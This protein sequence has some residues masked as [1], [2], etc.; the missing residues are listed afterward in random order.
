[1]LIPKTHQTDVS[2]CKIL[3]DNFGK[4]SFCPSYCSDVC[5]GNASKQYIQRVQCL[6]AILIDNCIVNFWIWLSR[7]KQLEM[8]ITYELINL[9]LSTEHS[10]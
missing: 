7:Y 10:C 3:P 2:L 9:Y 1:M 8:S 6:L 5:I 4:N